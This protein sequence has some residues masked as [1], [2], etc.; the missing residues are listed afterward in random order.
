MVE[1]N[2]L[3]ST[4]LMGLFLLAIVVVIARLRS[5]S[6]TATAS[7]GRST[8]SELPDITPS[9]RSTETV[10]SEIP[11]TWIIGFLLLVLAAGAGSVLFIGASSLPS[12]GIGT[13]MAGIGLAIVIGGLV[14]GY[15]V[16]GIYLSLRSH[17]RKS[18]E[19]TGV[20]IWLLGLL[21]V[22]VIVVNLLLGS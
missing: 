12:I 18:A 6:E 1:I 14:C 16:S 17:G 11:P 20:A 21:G 15:F 10:S 4:L 9:A 2:Y 7:G 3:V 13:Q 22:G 19:A 8:A 5:V